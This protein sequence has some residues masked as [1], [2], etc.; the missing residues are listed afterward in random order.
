MDLSLNDL[1]F[2]TLSLLLIQPVP[3]LFSFSFGLKPKN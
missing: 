1:Y 2:S 3:I